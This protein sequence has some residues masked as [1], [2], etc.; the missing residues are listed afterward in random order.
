MM[1]HSKFSFLLLNLLLVHLPL[2][3]LSFSVQAQGWVTPETFILDPLLTNALQEASS[4]SLNVGGLS[5]ASKGVRVWRETLVKGRLPVKD[6]FVDITIWPV[7]PLFS[8]LSQKMAL[9]NLPRF[10]FN[11]PETINAVLLSLIRITIEYT[12]EIS[13]L[14]NEHQEDNLTSDEISSHNIRNDEEGQESQFIE[15]I[16]IDESNSILADAEE[17]AQEICEMLVKEFSGVVS[18]VGILD[19]LFGLDHELLVV[20]KV[21]PGGSPSGFGI[22]DGIWQHSGTYYYYSIFF[23]F[24]LI[25]FSCER[26]FIYL[27]I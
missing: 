16:L 17:V 22:Q 11:H 14:G 24:L 10:V 6:D 21:T 1:Q 12:R 15:N 2:S 27:F 19:Q 8:N 4:S 26:L 25:H 5:T 7:E 13:L 3:A 23:C 18:G 20:D 9:L